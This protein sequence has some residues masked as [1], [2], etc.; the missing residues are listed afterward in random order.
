MPK[1]CLHA[2]RAMATIG[3]VPKGTPCTSWAL[4]KVGSASSV[5]R[6]TKILSIQW[7]L[8]LSMGLIDG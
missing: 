2:S 4:A 3:A 7:P 8:D 5:M 6:N 1:H